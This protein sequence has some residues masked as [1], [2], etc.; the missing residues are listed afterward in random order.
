MLTF[1]STNLITERTKAI[2]LVTPPNPAV[3]ILGQFCEMPHDCVFTMEYS[4]RSAW[5]A[6]HALTDSVPEPP[7]VKHTDRN[8]AVLFRAARGLLGG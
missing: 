8:P 1:C 5:T 7:D 4:V 6:V 3:A 2:V